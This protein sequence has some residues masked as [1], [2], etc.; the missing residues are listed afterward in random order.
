MS[1]YL[2]VCTVSTINMVEI[3][4]PNGSDYFYHGGLVSNA[5]L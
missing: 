3:L 5:D 2:F 1:Y 4:L